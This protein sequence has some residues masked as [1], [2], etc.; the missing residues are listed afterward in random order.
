MIRFSVM[1]M[2]V[3]LAGAAQ[4]DDDEAQKQA[5]CGFQGDLMAAVQQARLDRVRKNTVTETLLAANPDWPA[6]AATAIPA[7]TDYV[8]SLKRRDL[9]D[10]D[11]GETTK[12]QCLENWEQLQALKKGIKN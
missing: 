3:V 11:L 12:T 8:Y 6:G 2:A 10:V 9:K 5:E 4:A 7:L 1:A